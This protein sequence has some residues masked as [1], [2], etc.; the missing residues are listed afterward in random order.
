MSENE[1][2]PLAALDMP[3]LVY[4]RDD[5]ALAQGL[6]ETIYGGHATRR[7]AYERAERQRLIMGKAHRQL[8]KRLYGASGHDW[9]SVAERHSMRPSWWTRLWRWLKGAK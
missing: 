7:A 8:V 1:W 4:L 3:V 5:P 6:L 9:L 2:I